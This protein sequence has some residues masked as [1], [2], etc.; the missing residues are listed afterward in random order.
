MI[1]PIVKIPRNSVN[2]LFIHFESIA[3]YDEYFVVLFDLNIVDP[4]DK[5]TDELIKSYFA[6]K[7]AAYVSYL[8]WTMITKG[9]TFTH[10]HNPRT[11][12]WATVGF[13]QI[14][15]ELATRWVIDKQWIHWCIKVIK[16]IMIKRFS[17][18]V[19][20]HYNSVLSSVA[21]VIW[22][23]EYSTSYTVH[24]TSFFFSWAFLF[25]NK[26]ERMPFLGYTVYVSR[27]PNN[28]L[29][30]PVVFGIIISKGFS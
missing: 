25:N 21:L 24:N 4:I 10:S 28:F 29:S 9:G 17:I 14:S 6:I 20:F 27:P 19:T 15:K 8:W 30:D 26:T 13:P 12:P 3:L 16:V 7:C 18:L 2:P 1:M 22:K 11:P 23:Y 5:Q